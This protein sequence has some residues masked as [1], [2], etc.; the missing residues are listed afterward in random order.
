MYAVYKQA[1]PP[2]G[3][4]FS[5]YCNFFNNSER[6]LVVAG[7][8]QL[9]VYRL[10][11]DAEAPTKNDRSTEGKAHREHRE[12][13]ELVASFSFFGNV[14]S[15][16]SVQLAGAKRDA[17]LLSF[18]DAKL[19]VVEYDP[20]THDLKTL[21]LHYFEEP[22]LR[23]GL[24][25]MPP[26]LPWAPAPGQPHVPLPPGRLRAERAHATGA[27][28]PRRALRGH[29]HLRH[30]AGGP[31]LPPGEPGRGARGARGRRAEVQLPAQLH[32]RRAGPGR[33]AA[34]H[35][36]PAVPARLL[37]AHPA[38]PVRAQPDLA[39]A[40]GCAAG[41]VLH[42][43]HLPEHHAEGPPCHLVPHQPALRLHPGPGCAQAHRWGGDLCRQLP[44]V[45]EPERPPLRRGSQQ[46][47]HRHHCLPAAH[48]GGRADHPGLRPGRLHL[49][50]QDGHLPQGRRDLRA[51]PHHGR[52]AQRPGLPLRQGCCQCP[53][54]QHGHHGARV[55]VSWLSLGQLPAPQIHRKAAGAPSRRHPRGC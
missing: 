31:A 41:H 3:L 43:G 11:R 4:E 14:M 35:R 45:P 25:A 29:A 55:P 53:H 5:M 17:L 26:R 28:G 8:S 13:L 27:G 6:N 48:P 51:D 37:R 36:G 1:H 9:Y 47:H 2:T 7:T 18:K 21:S 10:N 50:R 20:G 34:Q 22:E 12:K 54:H 24:P 52:H 23:V 40:R 39:G 46:P 30:A 33:E 16:A 44:A 19:S 49:L 42:R 38:H 32:H 15:M